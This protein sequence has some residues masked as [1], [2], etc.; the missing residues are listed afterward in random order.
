MTTAKLDLDGDY[1]EHVSATVAQV[2]GDEDINELQDNIDE[3]LDKA[4]AYVFNGDTKIAWVVI[5]IE[6]SN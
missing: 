1:V 5:R 6:D 3:A 2:R 4:Q